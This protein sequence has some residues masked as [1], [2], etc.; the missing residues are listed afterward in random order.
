[1]VMSPLHL[2]LIL[3]LV[4]VVVVV[5]MRVAGRQRCPRCDASLS[6][7]A[8]QCPHCGQVLGLVQSPLEA[9]Q[10]QGPPRYCPECKGE[11]RSEV[12]VCPDCSVVLQDYLPAPEPAEDQPGY[13]GPLKMLCSASTPEEADFLISVLAEQNIP[14]VLIEARKNYD[15]KNYGYTTPPL[16]SIGVGDIMVGEKD[17]S[18]AQEILATIEKDFE[19]SEPS[20]SQAQYSIE[21]PPG[22]RG[23][24]KTLTYATSPAEANFLISLLNEKGI[25]AIMMNK[26]REPIEI[27]NAP[28]KPVDS[29]YIMVGENDLTR[30]KEVIE[31]LAVGSGVGLEGNEEE[32]GWVCEEC[33]T[34]VGPHDR[35]CPKCGA[36]FEE[37]D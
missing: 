33:G 12:V 28:M 24:W 11:F 26:A 18:R 3:A 21:E 32:A 27:I 8:R 34:D 25:P 5:I 4:L 1:M 23:S 14:A 30:A 36:E 20:D 13:R 17:L 37:D 16:F 10:A 22:L 9:R 6:R 7:S 19:T 35:V 2:V 31:A 29:G 15:Y